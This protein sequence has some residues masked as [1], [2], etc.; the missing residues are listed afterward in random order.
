MISPPES[1]RNN[2]GL[3]VLVIFSVFAVGLATYFSMENSEP[4]RL[5]IA[6][7]NS[8]GDSFVISQALKTVVERHHP[9][10]RITV[11]ETGGTSENLKLLEERKVQLAAAQADVP[12][13]DSA[14]SVAVL[15]RDTFQLAVHQGSSI[16]SFGD[17]RGKR[18]ALPQKGG[19]F[20]SFL[21]LANHF[22]LRDSD[23][24]FVGKDD[25]GSDEAFEAGQADAVFRV[26]AL[27][28]NAIVHLAKSSRVD[29]VPID[30]ASAMQIRAP[31]FI[32][33][34][35]PQGAYSGKPAIPPRDLPTVGVERTLL[36]HDKVSDEAIRAVT[37]ILLE[38]RHEVALA[39]PEH[40]AEI[41]PLLAGVQQPNTQ[42]GLGVAIH[43]GAKA[44]YEKDVPSYYQQYADYLGLWVTVGLLFGSWLWEGRRWF[45]KRQKNLADRYNRE[46][47]RLIERAHEAATVEN[48]E[49][50][51][52]DLLAVL[53]NAV[54]DLDAN[55][56]TQE[57]FQSFRD[58]WQI[59]TDA[60]RERNICLP[61]LM[62]PAEREQ[63]RS[64]A[65]S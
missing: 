11:M 54:R 8:T 50:V 55:K 20:K 47:I 52:A 27:S 25:H 37:A 65:H 35:I 45:Q 34:V 30:Q 42:S 57:S 33:T 49:A 4:E 39:I 48:L 63:A 26:R 64:A 38:N 6:A 29:F 46:V 21:A 40:L 3:L 9:K 53:M 15:F 13:P 44:Y 41:R 59:A 61:P 24:S 17:L 18:I 62:T 19:Q 22:G 16:K 12:A 10:L 60:V 58:L 31:A 56:V 14:R 32:P 5:T 1:N 7:G 28:N 23:F 36:T 2:L 43:A 51:R